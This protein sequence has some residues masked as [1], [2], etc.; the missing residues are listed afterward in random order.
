MDFWISYF[1]LILCLAL[2]FI[3]VFIYEI[4]H[5]PR[6]KGYATVK[7]D[8]G[9]KYEGYWIDYKKHGKGVY[10]WNEGHIYS[11]EWMSDKRSGYGEMIWANKK[12]YRGTWRNDKLCGK[13]IM[14]CPDGV[15]KGG[16]WKNNKLIKGKETQSKLPGCYL[17][18]FI[19]QGECVQPESITISNKESHFLDN[20]FIMHKNYV[21]YYDYYIITYD[22]CEHFFL[23]SDT[24][25]TLVCLGDDEKIYDFI[26]QMKHLL[27]LYTDESVKKALSKNPKFCDLIFNENDSIPNLRKY[28]NR[29]VCFCW[30]DD[31][32]NYKEVE[33][34]SEYQAAT[35]K[36]IQYVQDII[37]EFDEFK[38]DKDCLI[39]DKDKEASLILQAKIKTFVKKVGVIAA[40]QA[41][42]IALLVAGGYM[43]MD[44][45]LGDDSGFDGDVGGGMDGDL[46]F[47]YDADIESLALPMSIAD[48]DFEIDISDNSDSSDLEVTENIDKLND[49]EPSL[50]EITN[51]GYNVS[52][53]AQKETLTS[54]GGGS[55]I[56][57][58][59]TKE[60]GTS[61]EFCIKT[62]KGTVHNITNG[63][64]WVKINGVKYKL[65]KLKG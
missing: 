56:E 51:G 27:Q 15:K 11:G 57:A 48:M 60:P 2:L 21:P 50:K 18:Y 34:T 28:N 3:F 41:V 31:V 55:H 30:K 46:S 38:F 61:N 53:G 42:K 32:E 52:F 65:P 49:D 14:R 9:D 7:F 59:I 35:L 44:L 20:A 17:S 4:R 6:K 62:D 45:I 13:G 43:G 58:T 19:K 24:R 63:D 47:D 23:K 8:N 36:R 26:I 5:N 29:D 1:I 64:L 16:I 40:K 33:L 54:Q 37:F 25:E 10:R 39:I 22:I 12:E